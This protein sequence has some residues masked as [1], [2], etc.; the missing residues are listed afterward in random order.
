MVGLSQNID[1]RAAAITRSSK[2]AAER[3]PIDVNFGTSPM[4]IVRIGRFR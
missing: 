4:V 2:R 3:T 1:D